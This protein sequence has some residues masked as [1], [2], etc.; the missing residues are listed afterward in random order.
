MP[1]NN[2]KKMGDSP[3]ILF[4]H[5]YLPESGAKKI[6]S[7]F[8]PFTIF[9]PWFME[10]PGFI[11]EADGLNLIQILKPPTNLKP[12]E[13]FNALLSEYRLWIN[14]NQDKSYKEFLKASPERALAGN[15][16]WE[17]REMLR[18][19]D[20]HVSTS[21]EDH[22]LKWHLILHLARETE[23]QRL[24]ADKMLKILK[25][26]GSP[27]KGII[28][29]PGPLKNPL[30]DL[31]PFE[32]EPIIEGNLLSLVFEAWFALFGGYLKKDALLITLNRSVIDYISEDVEEVISG[33][34]PPLERFRIDFTLPDISQ[35]SLESIS[36]EEGREP[37]SRDIRELR[38]LLTQLD[39]DPEYHLSS[40]RNLS[41]EIGGSSLW[42]STHKRFKIRIQYLPSFPD[43][44]GPEKDRL[45]SSLS[46]KTIIL[47]EETRINPS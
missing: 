35:K 1:S 30:E 27:L 40:L 15:T 20:R 10:K 37:L 6:I 25:E 23:E 44:G 42:E 21:Q 43:C 17:I 33:E 5:S 3:V 36:N 22:T 28:E 11:S 18:R 29:E 32:S 24:E 39:K 46:H 26:R 34:A 2:F 45:L 9:Q 14:D 7:F 19:M 38:N 13:G 16:T 41:R 31:S 12:K 4:P 47:L 8:G